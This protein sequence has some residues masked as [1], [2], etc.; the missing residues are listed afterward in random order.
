MN[1]GTDH[2][3][4]LIGLVMARLAALEQTVITLRVE[5][6]LFIESRLLKAVIY[7]RGNDEI[8]RIP[9]QVQ[10]LIIYRFR[11]VHI[12]VDPNIAA[13]IRPKLLLCGIGIEATGIHIR[14]T[15]LRR[16]V[17]E[18]LFKPFPV[19]NEACRSGKPGSRADDNGICVCK[20]LFQP[21]NIIRVS[22]GRFR[23]QLP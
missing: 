18:I 20:S 22:P 7:I 6:A 15:I 5:Q 21:F 17:R 3:F 8:V 11:R 16:K 12:S 14:K 9:Y 13:P 19:V 10:K 2:I 1:H 4:V 23:N